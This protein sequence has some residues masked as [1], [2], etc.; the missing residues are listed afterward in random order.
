MHGH[1]LTEGGWQL[2]LCKSLQLTSRHLG[3]Q[4]EVPA[5]DGFAMWA[6]GLPV[7]GHLPVWPVVINAAEPQRMFLMSNQN[8]KLDE[9]LGP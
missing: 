2:D 4:V 5:E 7:F 1:F 3:R 9:R 6:M 8:G